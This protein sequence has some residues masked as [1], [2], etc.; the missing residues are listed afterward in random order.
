MDQAVTFTYVTFRRF[1]G[2]FLLQ[3][4]FASFVVREEADSAGKGTTLKSKVIE[5]GPPRK[6]VLLFMYEDRTQ[7]ATSVFTMAIDGSILK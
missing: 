2:L 4:S 3:I 1:H 6:L 7:T 5:T